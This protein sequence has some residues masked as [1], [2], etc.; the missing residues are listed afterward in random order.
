MHK[1]DK[2][3]ILSKVGG[4]VGMQTMIVTVKHRSGA[5]SG[6]GEIHH[7]DNRH[8]WLTIEGD[9]GR[10]RSNEGSWCFYKSDLQL[11]DVIPEELWV[12]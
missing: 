2:V 7:I 10:G 4:D 5:Y 1:G 12:I 8:Y 6:I 11:V 3:K 9:N